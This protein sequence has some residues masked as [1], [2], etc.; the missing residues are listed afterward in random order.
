VDPGALGSAPHRCLG[1]FTARSSCSFVAVAPACGGSADPGSPA[2]AA[3][4][5]AFVYGE[6][7]V[8]PQGEAGERARALL[9]R[10]LGE[11]DPGR[12]IDDLLADDG[13][14]ATFSEDV[15]PWLGERI[16]GFVSTVEPEAE[17]AGFLRG[18]GV[19]EGLDVSGAAAYLVQLDSVIRERG[20]RATGS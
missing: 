10:L 15:E 1:V 7:T 19:G 13:S 12:A 4:V 6:A 2:E 5:G 18:L 8:R 3:P 9:R 17:A 14:G 20:S 16:G 11:D